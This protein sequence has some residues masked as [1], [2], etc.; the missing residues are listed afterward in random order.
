L[1]AKGDSNTQLLYDT[2]KELADRRARM[3]FTEKIIAGKDKKIEE[4]EK[5]RLQREHEFEDLET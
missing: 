5:L 3:G 4:L 2:Q 1:E